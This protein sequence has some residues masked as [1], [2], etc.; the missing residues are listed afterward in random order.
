MWVLWVTSRKKVV[1]HVTLKLS[2]YLIYVLQTHCISFFPLVL[3]SCYC[4]M[5]KLCV[6]LCGPMNCSTWGFL[7]LDYLL[8]FAQIHVHLVSDAIQPSYPVNPFS[9]YPCSPRDSQDSSQTPQFKNINSSASIL[10]YN[11]TL[12]STHDYWKNHTLTIRT[13]VSK[14]MSLLF[15]MLSR[16]VIGPG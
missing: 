7:V 8:E 9:S 11:P 16:F 10:L 14:V 3:C 2:V 12:T 5:A 4:S 1:L 15:N 6:M 13:F